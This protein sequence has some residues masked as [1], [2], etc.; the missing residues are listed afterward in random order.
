MADDARSA[1]F[2][3]IISYPT[4][5]RANGIIVLFNSS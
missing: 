1:E 2:D 3:V 4:P 5:A